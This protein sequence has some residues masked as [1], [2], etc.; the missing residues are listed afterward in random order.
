[1]RISL[2]VDPT[3]LREGEDEGANRLQLQLF[4]QRVLSAIFKSSNEIPGSINEVLYHVKEETEK[5][6]NN[7]KTSSV[8]VGS[9]MFLRFINPAIAAPHIF[10][11]TKEPPNEVC[12]RFCV[13]I[14]KIFQNLAN[15]TLPGTKEPYMS[16]M[17]DFIRGHISEMEEFLNRISTVHNK[18]LTG[19]IPIPENVK[20]QSLLEILHINNEKKEQIKGITEP[21]AYN[22]IR[23]ILDNEDIKH[24]LEANAAKV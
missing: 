7:L 3:R 22:E 9:F 17:N 16:A 2:E 21:E 23:Q 5:Q 15:G 11:I 20:N 1:M 14:S 18:P 12:Q 13:L 6:F 24:I 10:G 4:A 19:G 8:A